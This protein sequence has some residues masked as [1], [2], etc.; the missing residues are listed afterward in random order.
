MHDADG[1][2]SGAPLAAAPEGS[3]ARADRPA[4]GP[5]R[6]PLGAEPRPHGPGAHNQTAGWRGGGLLPD[7]DFESFPFLSF[8]FLAAQQ[9]SVGCDGWRSED[10]TLG[11]S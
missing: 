5:G 9:P 2:A 10:P 3:R 11:S 4:E 6:W 8:H 1:A 7:G